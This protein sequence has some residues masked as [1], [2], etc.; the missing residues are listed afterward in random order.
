MVESVVAGGEYNSNTNFQ[1]IQKKK[2]H[3][4]NKDKK[5]SIVSPKSEVKKQTRRLEAKDLLKWKNKRR[6]NHRWISETAFLAI[7]RISS[8][9]VCATCFKTW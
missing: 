5:I 6:D 2:E 8:E 9:C 4:C 1:Q 3:F 7:K